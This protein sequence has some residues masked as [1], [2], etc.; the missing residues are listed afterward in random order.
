MRIL[1]II[2]DLSGG[3]AEKLLA[4]FV[5]LMVKRGHSVDVLL[6]RSKGSVYITLLQD[7]GVNV[8]CLTENSIYSLLN[9]FRIRKFI[10]RGH[11]DVV[12]VHLFPGLY[13]VSIVCLLQ[14]INKLV[15]TEHST[16]NRRIKN[17][18][19]RIVER[20]IYI[21]YDKVICITEA[22]RQVMKAHLSL[23]NAEQKLVTVE[24]GICLDQYNNALV[25][26]RKLIDE[27]IED[28][29]VIITMVARFSEQKDH[30]TVVR[31]MA[32][33]PENYKLVLVG[34]G[35]LKPKIQEV[36]ER[37]NLKKR[38]FLPG[39]RKDVPSILKSSDIAVLSSHWEGF[40]LAAVEAMGCGVPV[41]ASDVP[42]LREVVYGAG[43]LFEKGNS[44]ELARKIILLNENRKVYQEC[45]DKCL[46]RA[47]EYSIEKMIDSYIQVYNC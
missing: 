4:D 27:G 6:L 20:W 13:I 35:N 12:H 33:L 40:G 29:D 37:L 42:G 7:A 22:V 45:V 32:E 3:G 15:F 39:F 11:Y 16:N 26:D 18:V 47:A 31:A 44:R 1:Q 30:E 9:V 25:L 36:A 46:R 17:G 28:G 38:V 23:S 10:K 2:G 43:Y 41:I 24:N 21:P 19:L 5:P 8:T 34:E 14:K